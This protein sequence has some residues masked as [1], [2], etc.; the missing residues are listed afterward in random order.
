MNRRFLAGGGLGAVAIEL[1]EGPPLVRPLVSSTLVG[2]HWS[3]DVVLPDR[4]IPLRWLEIRWLDGTWGWRSLSDQVDTIGGGRLLASGWR[5]FQSRGV[6]LPGVGRIQLVEKSPPGLLLECLEDR[7]LFNGESIEEYLEL[8]DGQVLPIGW[9]GPDGT[10]QLADG[11]VLSVRGRIFRVHLPE[12][13]PPTQRSDLVLDHPDCHLDIDVDQLTATFTLGGS[14]CTVRGERV[15]AL[16][17]YAAAAKRQSH[18]MDSWVEMGA[19]FDHWVDLGGNK[20]SA[21][22]RIAWERGKLRTR[23]SELGA[24][25]VAGL[26]ESRRRGRKSETRL[27]LPADAITIRWKGVEFEG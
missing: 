22:D 25:G 5:A 21:R 6:R 13:L 12:G 24:R 2:R 4:R 27:C 18:G 26:C 17:P 20:D 14:E 7:S 11:Q 8:R 3:C 10:G 16:V 23:L 9:E 15:R 1:G 19:A